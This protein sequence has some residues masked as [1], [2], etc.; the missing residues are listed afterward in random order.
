VIDWRSYDDVAETYERVHAPR[1]GEVARDLVAFVSPNAGGHALD[2]GTGTGVAA[3]A[4]AEALGEGGLAVGADVSVPMMIAGRGRKLVRF[5]AAEAIDLPFPNGSFDLVTGNFV[6]H[7]FR[8][9]DTALFDLLRV[10]RPGGRLALSTWGPGVDDLE[11][12]W[13]SLVVETVGEEMFRDVQRQ[14]SP[15]RDRF[16]RR[17]PIEETLLDAGLRHVRTEAREYRFRF[18]LDEWIEGRAALP[19]GRFLQQM[20]GPEAYNRFRQRA[21]AVYAERFSDPLNDFRDVW[22]ATGTKS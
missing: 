19:T 7:H 17:E 18:G 15:W 11:R 4:A 13:R 22:L 3:A 8:R 12:T 20:I 14:A 5:V 16:S 6:L 1:L 10:L 9:Y 21:R 2:V